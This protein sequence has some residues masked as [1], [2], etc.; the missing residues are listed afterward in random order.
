MPAFAAISMHV[1]DSAIVLTA[2]SGLS[3]FN[4]YGWLLTMIL[5]TGEVDRPPAIGLIAET[6]LV[7]NVCSNAFSTADNLLEGISDCKEDGNI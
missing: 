7:L 6:S 4:T 1:D 5:Y 2:P 3:N